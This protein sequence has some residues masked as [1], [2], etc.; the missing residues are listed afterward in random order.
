LV[1]PFDGR[2][3]CGDRRCT[4]EELYDRQK[5]RDHL[6]WAKR[7]YDGRFKEEIEWWG[8]VYEEMMEKTGPICHLPGR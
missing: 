3:I 8:G 1:K 6:E 2:P 5:H 4:L 7:E